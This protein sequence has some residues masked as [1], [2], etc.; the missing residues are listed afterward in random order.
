MRSKTA[1]LSL[2][3]VVTS[4]TAQLRYDTV[5]TAIVGPGIRSTKIVVRS[6]P[7]SIDV[8]EVDLKD[9]HVRFE[10]VKSHDRLFAGLERTSS[11]AA[12]YDAPSHYVVAAV[13][14]DFFDF[15]TSNPV[16][17]QVSGGEFL[18][19]VTSNRPAVGFLPG[20]GM[21]FARPAFSGWVRVHDVTRS[22]NAVNLT[23]TAGQLVLYNPMFGASTGTASGGTEVVLTALTPWGTNDSVTCL[24]SSAGIGA[25]NTGL[26]AGTAVLSGDGAAGTYLSGS[27]PVDDTVT[28]ATSVIAGLPPIRELISGY[29]F[30]VVN[31]AR[32]S[33]DPNDSFVSTRNPRTMVGI[34]ADTTRLFLVVVDGRQALLSAG[35]TLIEASD[36]L[37]NVLHIS[38]AINLDGGGSSTMVVRGQVVNSPSDPGGERSVA[39]ALLVVSTAAAG[40]LAMLRLSEHAVDVFQGSEHRFT[41]EGKDEFY[42]PIP[43]PVTVA[44]SCDT[45]IGTID[46]TGLFRARNTNDS[47]WVRIRDGAVAD[48]AFVVVRVIE[49]LEVFPSTLVMVPGERVRLLVR[50]TDSDGNVALLRNDQVHYSSGT[51]AA[52]IDADGNVTATAFGSGTVTLTL[53]TVTATLGFNASGADTTVTVERF[54]S[55]KGWTWSLIN[56]DADNFSFGLTDQPASADTPAFRIAYDFSTTG[57]RVML[58]TS[59]PLSSRVD[60]L[61]LQVYGDG[62][63]HTVSLFF[64][65]KDGEQFFITSPTVVNWT[66]QW[67][68]VSFRMPFAQAVS[69]GTVDYPITVTG[70]DVILG[71]G[72]SV[73][74]RSTGTVVLDDLRAHYPNRAVAPQVLFDFNSGISGWLQPWGVG[75]G[76]TKGVRKTGTVLE[77]STAHPYE[78]AGCGR[79]TFVDSA[80]INLDW[81][82]RI[83]RTSAELGSMLRGSYIGAWVWADGETNL[84]MRTVIRDGNSQ[85]CEGPPFPVRHIGWK[86]IGTR[87]DASAFRPYLTSGTITDVNNRFN[88]FHVEGSDANLNGQTRVLFIDKMVTSALTVPTGFTEYSALWSRPTV[89]LRWAVNS[90][91]SVSRY[92]IERGTGG[93]FTEIGSVAGVGNTD[94]TQRYSFDDVPSTE[95]GYQYRIRQVTNDGAQELSP[96]LN[97]NVVL[98]VEVDGRPRELGLH[99]NYPNPFNPSTTI[100]YALPKGGIVHLR[101]FNLL[102]Q[103]VASLVDG[104]RDAGRYDVVFDAGQLASGM[105]IYRLDAAGTHIARK[106]MLVK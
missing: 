16:S 19:S 10:A 58:R 66:G 30:L 22:L 20:N 74:G 67:K 41:A 42:N 8:V 35:M 97:V 9:P 87:L 72:T 31:G 103:E 29:P 106:L 12:R 23:R 82:I 32:A 36:F 49:R 51:S 3:L 18:H 38:Q 43:L 13:N 71:T 90:E 68:T 77:Y 1:I 2:L 70:I 34:N 94:T 11:I 99:Q 61:F 65:D 50:G 98:G 54:V 96:V 40:P 44:W 69:G 95:G 76:Q 53:D 89:Q 102:G 104:F 46:S 88:G 45:T 25:G 56:A 100:G 62:G 6:V 37:R 63:G 92:V 7:W 84:T 78:G 15:G 5:S 39:N 33:L 26:A 17:M 55:T 80:E 105:Y 93:M 14:A 52:H 86:L 81:S 60:S 24:V 4:A 48:S 73:G 79:W 64:T 28:I 21:T 59:L 101:V 27:C 91:I 83:A 75:S 47:G 57:A 85:I